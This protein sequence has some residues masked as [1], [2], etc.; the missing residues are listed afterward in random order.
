MLTVGIWSDHQIPYV[1][2]RAWSLALQIFA[3]AKLDLLVDNGDWMDCRTLTTRYPVAYG[4]KMMAEMR[5]EVEAARGRIAESHKAIRPKKRRFN[6]GNHEFRIPRSFW[7]S[8]HGSQMLGID[9][10]R[11]AAGLPALLHFHKYGIKYSGEYPAGTWVLGG[12]LPSGP[13]DCLVTHGMI[14]SK[15]AGQTANRTLD[16]AMANVVVGHCERMATVW[17][18]APGWRSYFAV[19]GGNLSLFATP[20]GRDIL[21]NYPF[22]SPDHLNKQQGIVMLYH[23]AGQWWPYTIPFHNGVAYWDGKKYKA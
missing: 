1:C 13:N 20:K 11:N 15:K 3:D 16:D 8:P 12:E 19:E 18:H 2:P 22:N 23:D 6:G 4:E 17:K 21:T 10:I 14:S 7:S 5:H 9:T